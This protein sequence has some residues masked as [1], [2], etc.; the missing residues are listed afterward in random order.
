M[1]EVASGMSGKGTW[2]RDSERLK[3]S[4]CTYIRLYAS[5]FYV[6]AKTF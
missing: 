2:S 4:V 1:K 6:L 5:I 3:L